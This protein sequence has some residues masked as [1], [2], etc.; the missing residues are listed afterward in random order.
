MDTI[1]RGT[2]ALLKFLY[3]IYPSSSNGPCVGPG[4]EFPTRLH[5]LHALIRSLQR[6][7]TKPPRRPLP[8]NVTMRIL[9]MAGYVS[10]RPI[11]LA[12][13]NSHK[14]VKSQGT[15]ASERWFTSLPLTPYDYG[16]FSRI[17][18]LALS[19]R[20]HDQG[21]APDNSASYSWF[22]ISIVSPAGTVKCRTDRSQLIWMSHC[23][24]V[25]SRDFVS[26]DGDPFYA[27]HEIWRNLEVG[28]KIAV[29][30]SAQYGG[31]EN[32]AQEGEL[33]VWRWY[34]TPTPKS[35]ESHAS[36]AKR[37]SRKTTTAAP[38]RSATAPAASESD[39]SWG[40]TPEG[41]VTGL[42]VLGAVVVSG[43]LMASRLS[44]KS[45]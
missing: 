22:E 16:E 14:S 5:F 7:S 43:V 23:N 25:A 36:N 26:L 31:W 27:D 44:N 28:D 10:L 6:G 32:H 4:L 24:R 45:N 3:N 18:R 34:P 2:T 38:Y 21:R 15:I 13:S 17:T 41:A 37:P 30:V 19:T 33:C 39:S 35:L 20:S 12:K 9:C 42:G 40:I 8:H 11:V 1:S 29:W